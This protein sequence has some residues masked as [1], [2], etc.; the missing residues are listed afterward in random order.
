[1]APFKKTVALLGTLC[2]VGCLGLLL[3]PGSPAFLDGPAWI[4]LLCWLG[5]GLAFYVTFG[6]KYLRTPKH[7]LDTLI[8]GKGAAQPA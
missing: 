6:E 1:V 7:E 3:V 8:L 4:A 2:S 5:L